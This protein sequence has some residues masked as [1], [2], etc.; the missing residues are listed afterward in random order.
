MIEEDVRFSLPPGA[1]TD[2]LPQLLNIAR[3]SIAISRNEC[4]RFT[5]S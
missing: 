4:L 3:S 1:A 2:V 5:I